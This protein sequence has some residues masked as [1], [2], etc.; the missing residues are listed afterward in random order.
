MWDGLHLTKNTLDFLNDRSF[1]SLHYG[2]IGQGKSTNAL[3]KL[4]IFANSENPCKDGVVRTRIGFARGAK[5]E[6]KV[7]FPKFMQ[8]FEYKGLNEV[9]YNDQKGIMKVTGFAL[10]FTDVLAGKVGAVPVLRKDADGNPMKLETSIH[11]IGSDNERKN[12]SQRSVEYSIIHAEEADIIPAHSLKTLTERARWQPDSELGSIGNQ[13]IMTFNPPSP[14]S[15]LRNYYIKKAH[16]KERMMVADPDTG[17]P[18][19]TDRLMCSVF[20]SVPVFFRDKDVIKEGCV[21]TDANGYNY[22]PNP[23]GDG[24]KLHAGTDF[25]HSGTYAGIG[26]FLQVLKN[27]ESD[28]EIRHKLFGEFAPRHTDEPVYIFKEEKHVYG[29]LALIE[30]EYNP[31]LAPKPAQDLP[32]ILS[33]DF[34]NH[35]ACLISQIGFDGVLYCLDELYNEH[36]WSLY[37]LI[38]EGLSRLLMN[39]YQDVKRFIIIGDPTANQGHDDFS[40]WEQ[41]KK[42]IYMHHNKTEEVKFGNWQQNKL[43]MKNSIS[44]RISETQ[45]LLDA[46]GKVQLSPYLR[47]LVGGLQGD[48]HYQKGYAGDGFRS[49]PCKSKASHIANCFEYTCL[50]A[51]Y[52]DANSQQMSRILNNLKGKRSYSGSSKVYI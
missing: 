16:L 43:M 1:I 50:F 2:G 19:E 20:K 42:K 22:Y 30:D 17:L 28:N 48:Y 51:A 52:Q 27:A 31:D 29:G 39:R 47:W 37:S 10:D 12:H 4:F 24:L 13:V 40:A 3:L 18:V 15:V 33:F 46:S 23:N 34:G 5:V 14:D 45:K 35:P 44:T 26:Y 7:A 9:T 38:D 36:Y 8:V 49:V 25:E 21:H 6:A 41:I 32:L 11:A